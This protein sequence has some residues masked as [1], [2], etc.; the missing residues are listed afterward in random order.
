[1]QLKKLIPTV[2]L[3]VMAMGASAQPNPPPTGNGGGRPGQAG[4]I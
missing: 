3:A 2:L 1:M 4:G